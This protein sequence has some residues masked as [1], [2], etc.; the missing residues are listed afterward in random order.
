M[1]RCEEKCENCI[2][3]ISFHEAQYVGRTHISMGVL[4][5]LGI[6]KLRWAYW[7]HM[8]SSGGNPWGEMGVPD[9]DMSRT[10]VNL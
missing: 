8:S 9:R 2:L 10:L 7:G 6:I 5:I 3:F 4:G 1:K